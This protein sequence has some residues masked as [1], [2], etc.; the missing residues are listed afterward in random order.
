MTESQLVNLIQGAYEILKIQKDFSPA[1][2]IVK[3]TLTE[4]TQTLIEQN[5]AEEGFCNAVL[6]NKGVCNCI[7]TLRDCCQLAEFE[8]EVFWVKH[9]ID[10]GY[11]SVDEL[12][13]FPEF[14]RYYQIFLNEKGLIEKNGIPGKNLIFVGSGPLPMTGIMITH[15]TDYIVDLADWNAQAIELSK[16]VCANLCPNMRIIHN[17]ALA[18]DYSGYDVVFI[19]SMLINKKALIDKLYN[20]GVKYIVIRDAKKFSQLF[21]EQLDNDI[22]L[23][24]RIKEVL[25]SQGKVLNSSYLLERCS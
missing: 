9:F 14:N 8:N 1:N 2:P 5:N 7:C 3:K 18:I 12:K 16:Q 19:A 20:T 17:D 24:Y 10:K 21:Y 11:R 25:G 6:T 23:K 4:L 22:F 15:F 13:V